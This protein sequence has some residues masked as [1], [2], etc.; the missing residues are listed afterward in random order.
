MEAEINGSF[1]ETGV[2]GF[3]VIERKCE[4]GFRRGASGDG[5]RGED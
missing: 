5:R 4:V 1:L 2:G 3:V